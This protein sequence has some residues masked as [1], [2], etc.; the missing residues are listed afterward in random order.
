M[1]IEVM[2]K[3]GNGNALLEWEWVGMGTGMIRWEWEGNGN[4]KVIPALYSVHAKYHFG[5]S[6]CRYQHI[7]RERLCFYAEGLQSANAEWMF[8][9]LTETS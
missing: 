6:L 5:T 2:G 7:A 8:S 4:K 3:N 1:G 9:L